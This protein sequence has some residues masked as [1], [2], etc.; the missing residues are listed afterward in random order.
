MTDTTMT[1]GYTLD[2]GAG[3]ALWAMGERLVLK[4]TRAQTGGAF[5]IFEDLVAAGGEPPPHV[6]ER[7]DE[8]YYILE[9]AIAVTVGGQTYQ[10][11]PGAF[12]FLPRLVPHHWQVTSAEPVRMLVFF[13]PAGVEGFFQALSRPAEAPTT[14]PPSPPDLPKII[15]TA[16]EYGIRLAGPPPA[17]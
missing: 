5:T 11:G 16:G 1:Q 3:E 17:A 12:V 13:T 2:A 7:E 8:A 9:G 14:P 6:H 4:A 15:Q 10:A